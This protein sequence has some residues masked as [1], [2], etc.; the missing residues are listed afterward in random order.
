MAIVVSDNPWDLFPE[1][2]HLGTEECGNEIVC[3]LSKAGAK[4]VFG[5]WHDPAAILVLAATEAHFVETF[6][7]LPDDD[8][9]LTFKPGMEDRLFERVRA[10]DR[11][12]LRGEAMG[13]LGAPFADW[14]QALPET[15]RIADLRTA[16]PGDG[17]MIDDWRVARHP[18]A[19][20]FALLPPEKK[21]GLLGR[22]FGR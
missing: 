22:L 20:V 8:T 4:R 13:A 5:L 1:H 17:F 15:A 2:R 18:E 10:V 21:P 11:M 9:P 6:G 14:L 16:G 3:D 12:P 19:L 7:P